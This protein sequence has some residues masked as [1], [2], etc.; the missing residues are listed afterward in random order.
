MS[1]TGKAKLVRPLNFAP[2][3]TVRP[4]D[5][6]KVA[7]ALG[8]EPVGPVQNGG[9]PLTRVLGQI[10]R[11]QQA[12]GITGGVIRI[13]GPDLVVL[14]NIAEAMA[15]EGWKPTP[16]QVASMLLSFALESMQQAKPLPTMTELAQKLREATS[17]QSLTL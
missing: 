2:P 1:N 12:A 14:Q 4:L 3:K 17:E 9:S 5:M 6:N 10:D 7:A 11:Q 16:D 8:A 15:S 13:T